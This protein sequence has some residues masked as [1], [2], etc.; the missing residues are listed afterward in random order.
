MTLNLDHDILLCNLDCYGINDVADKLLK[1]YLADKN[2]IHNVLHS[3]YVNIRTGVPQGSVLGPLL[4]L[5]YINDFPKC[6]SFFDV[7]MYADDTK[8]VILQFE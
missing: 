3:Q 6:S 5:V 2:N 4:F 7:F 1:S 8:Y